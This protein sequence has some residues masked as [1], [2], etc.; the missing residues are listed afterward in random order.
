[1]GVKPVLGRGFLPEEDRT[2][3]THPVMVLSHSLWQRRFNADPAIVGKT[4]YLNGRPFTVVGVMPESFLGSAFYFRQAFWVPL[5]MAQK[6]GRAR[7]GRRIA[8][9]RRS[10]CTAG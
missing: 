7:S 4:I 6:F 9:M 1:M 10:I 2:P 8:A 5:M 3:N